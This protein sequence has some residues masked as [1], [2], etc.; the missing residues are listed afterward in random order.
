MCAA[1]SEL[2]QATATDW[3]FQSIVASLRDNNRNLIWVCGAFLVGSF[4]TVAFNL[5]AIETLAIQVAGIEGSLVAVAPIRVMLT[6]TCIVMFAAVIYV[7]L[8]QQRLEL[9]LEYL[10]RAR[11][12]EAVQ[13]GLFSDWLGQNYPVVSRA[14]S[15]A[16]AAFVVFCA[17]ILVIDIATLFYSFSS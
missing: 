5:G 3:H 9:G 4:F 1:P 16:I 6:V 12:S 10:A 15:L 2:D 17:A 7:V 13:M 8:E 14:K 11:Q